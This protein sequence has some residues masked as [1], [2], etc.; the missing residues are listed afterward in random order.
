MLAG[1]KLVAGARS[2]AQEGKF[3]DN[4][5]DPTCSGQAYF[6]ADGQTCNP[7]TFMDGV[8]DGLGGRLLEGYGEGDDACSILRIGGYW[9]MLSIEPVAVA[10]Q[11]PRSSPNTWYA[12]LEEVF[13]SARGS[14]FCI[15]GS[16]VSIT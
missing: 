4:P 13:S 5:R 7:Q 3:G 11:Q 1:A 2:G 14:C 10:R 16:S 12:S 8:F 6:V 9:M 15:C